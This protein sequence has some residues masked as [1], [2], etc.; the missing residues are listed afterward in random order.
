[1]SLDEWGMAGLVR[2]GFYLVAEEVVDATEGRGLHPTVSS[3][4]RVR[5]QGARD[6][7]LRARA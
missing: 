7:V 3:P 4:Q 6:P 5:R 1:M 2:F